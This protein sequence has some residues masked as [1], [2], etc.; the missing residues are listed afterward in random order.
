MNW[1][2][3]LQDE[4]GELDAF[5]LPAIGDQSVGCLREFPAFHPPNDV[6]GEVGFSSFE[7]PDVSA[8]L[9]SPVVEDMLPFNTYTLDKLVDQEIG[10]GR[11]R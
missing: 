4:M 5:L 6:L 2:G 8:L 11:F 1:Q 3:V 10:V 7:C 9:L